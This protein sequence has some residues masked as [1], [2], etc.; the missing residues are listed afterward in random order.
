MIAALRTLALGISLAGV[1][2][3]SAAAWEIPLTTENDK[4]SG[5]PPY[6]SGG[7][8]LLAGQAKEPTDLTLAVKGPDGKL[9]AIPAQFRVLAR[10]WRG[11][12]EAR[13]LPLSLYDLPAW[14]EL[15][16]KQ[17]GGT[18]YVVIPPGYPPP[19]EPAQPIGQY[20]VRDPRGQV[21]LWV[22]EVKL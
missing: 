18:V 14:K 7:V 9:T 16:Q 5:V 10:Y 1:L 8:P 13:K 11:S 2:A 17:A 12:E 20:E 22:C 4:R 6:I 15:E 19:P 21:V 3:A